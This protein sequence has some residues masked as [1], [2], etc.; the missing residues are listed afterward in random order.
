M[1]SRNT[2]LLSLILLTTSLFLSSLVGIVGAHHNMMVQGSLVGATY[3]Y[4]IE[5]SHLDVGEYFALTLHNPDGA[6]DCSTVEVIWGG[7]GFD[8][9]EMTSCTDTTVIFICDSVTNPTGNFR[10]QIILKGLPGSVPCWNWIA[11]SVQ[12]G[13]PTANEAMVQ[14][15]VGPVWEKTVGGVWIPVDKF[16]LLAPYIGLASTILVATVATAIYAKRVK[17]RKEKQ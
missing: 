7:V 5:M 12:P 14:N 16:G 4:F 17:R 6:I 3:S 15:L 10:G 9:I 8:R 13:K 1:R 11:I 2:P